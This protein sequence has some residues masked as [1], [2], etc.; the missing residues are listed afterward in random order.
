MAGHKSLPTHMSYNVADDKYLKL[1]HE[2]Y[3]RT[4]PG[5]AGILTGSLVL[6]AWLRGM[7]CPWEV[8]SSSETQV[9]SSFSISR[10][11]LDTQIFPRTTG[12]K[13]D[14]RNGDG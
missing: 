10:E 7:R 14:E 9:V 1:I 5:E 6:P 8:D 12:Y 13:Y 4:K 3:E 11:C 2:K